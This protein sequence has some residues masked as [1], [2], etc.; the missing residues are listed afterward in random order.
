MKKLLEIKANGTLRPGVWSAAEDEEL[1]A[2]IE[3]KGMR[4]GEIASHLN[5]KVH[6]GVK[7]RTGKQCKE[8]WNNHL[9][10]AINRSAWTKVED[11]G[12]L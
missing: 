12:L 1:K 8:R 6:N 2:Q 7:L 4:W 3:G 11:I 5:L 10:P 9:N